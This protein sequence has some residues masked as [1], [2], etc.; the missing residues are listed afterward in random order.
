M[1]LKK[2]LLEIFSVKIKEMKYDLKLFKYSYIFVFNLNHLM[3]PIYLIAASI[4]IILL[5][6]SYFL[7][8]KKKVKYEDINVGLDLGLQEI[9][10]GIYLKRNRGTL[11]CKLS[12]VELGYKSLVITKVTASNPKF[13]IKPFKS[14]VY[15]LPLNSNHLTLSLTFDSRKENFVDIYENVKFDV[16]GYV[17]IS[18]TK[19]IDFCKRDLNLN[20]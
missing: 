19:K 12:F 3:E 5:I 11:L 8:R 20:F 2:F 4:L 10:K 18:S 17:V 7:K 14:L 16:Y 15:P 9:E 13:F 6:I 1:L